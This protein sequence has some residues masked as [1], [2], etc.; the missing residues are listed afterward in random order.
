MAL[1]PD[2]LV[3]SRL[4]KKPGGQQ[5]AVR[6]TIWGGKAQKLVMENGTPKGAARYGGS[7]Q[8]H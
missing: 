7:T 4:N 6:D 8:P 1:A 3:T 2:A 5:P